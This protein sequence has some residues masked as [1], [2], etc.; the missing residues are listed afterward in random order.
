MDAKYLKSL[1]DEV[2]SIEVQN[3]SQQIAKYEL[4]E[5]ASTLFTKLQYYKAENELLKKRIEMI[6]KVSKGVEIYDNK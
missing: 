2:S 4:I 5:S 1:I 3:E 6:I